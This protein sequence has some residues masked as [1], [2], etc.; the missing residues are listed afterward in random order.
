MKTEVAALDAVV[1]QYKK[2]IGNG[3][4]ETDELVKKFNDSLY[5]AGLQKVIDEKQSQFDEWLK[6][7]GK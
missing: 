1:E 3:A 2:V 4:V 5:A 7:Q 6:T